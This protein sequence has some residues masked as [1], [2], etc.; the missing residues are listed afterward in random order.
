MSGKLYPSNKFFPSHQIN[1]RFAHFFYNASTTF[2]KEQQ[3]IFIIE[4]L[5][6][7]EQVWRF[8]D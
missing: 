2:P 8:W 1:S 3:L 4:F 5:V 7:R 6:R